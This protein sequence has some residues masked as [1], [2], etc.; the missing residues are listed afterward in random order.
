MRHILPINSFRR[1]EE[2]L[3]IVELAIVVVI[4]GIVFPIFSVLLVNTYRDSY[5]SD[6]KV[7]SSSM[8]IQALAY[9]DDTVRSS[10]SFLTTTASPY[11]DVYGANNL[12]SSGGQAWSY[13]GTSASNRVLITQ[14]YATTVNALNTGRQP[15]FK[16]TPEFNCTT[17]MYYQ[18]Q[19]EYVTIFFVK[20]NTLY[21]RILT[22]NTSSLCAGNVQQQK[23]TC[24]PYIATGSRD[25]SC[26]ANDEILATNVSSFS[27]AYFQVTQDG[28]SDPVDA[29]FTST[30][31]D[32]LEGADY[33]NVSIT[34][35]SKG[36]GVTNTMTQRMTKVNQ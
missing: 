12:G 9:I 3:T 22:D 14:N 5:V 19:L 33:V 34:A 28:T 7:K 4:I 26:Q 13:K 32:I 23:R 30:D 29:P 11:T 6:N 16:N 17:Q 10:S 21:R 2:G 24:P 8:T 27:T 18:P 15:V 20:D 35:S 1:R 31:P 36:G 25:A